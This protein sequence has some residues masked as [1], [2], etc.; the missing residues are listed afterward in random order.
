MG[1]FL[2]PNKKLVNPKMRCSIQKWG[3]TGNPCPFSHYSSLVD[4]MGICGPGSSFMPKWA[5]CQVIFIVLQHFK[6]KIGFS[7]RKKKFHFK[8][9]QVTFSEKGTK[10]SS[11]PHFWKFEILENSLWNQFHSAVFP[12]DWCCPLF[13]T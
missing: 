3:R 1:K 12:L 7:T 5:D 4:E 8:I 10:I 11:K 6:L 9:L 13:W 2:E